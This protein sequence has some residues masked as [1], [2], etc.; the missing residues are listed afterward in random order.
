V[1]ALAV[2]AINHG[3]SAGFGVAWWIAFSRSL[4][5][6]V[7]IGPGMCCYLKPKMDRMRAAARCAA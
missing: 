2:A 3:L 1:P 6:G 5:A 4:P 7:A